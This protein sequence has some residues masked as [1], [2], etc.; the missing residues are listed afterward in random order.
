MPTGGGSEGWR[1]LARP[2]EAL[3]NVGIIA[4]AWPT[5]LSGIGIDQAGVDTSVIA[6]WLGHETVRTT[7]VYLHADPRLKERALARPA[8]PPVAP[9]RY[10]PPDSLLTFLE[11]L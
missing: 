10:R 5:L 6:L 8:P 4:A 9:G 3:W 1:D 7:Q 2:A 11:G